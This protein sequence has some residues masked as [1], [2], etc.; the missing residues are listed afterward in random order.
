VDKRLEDGI[1]E[2]RDAN[3]VCQEII[4]VFSWG[5]DFFSTGGDPFVLRHASLISDVYVNILSPTSW[6]NLDPIQNSNEP[7]NAK[8]SLPSIRF[9]DEPQK[10]PLQ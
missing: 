8:I 9:E 10:V 7:I 6:K 5:R 3:D 2:E 1:R 4:Y